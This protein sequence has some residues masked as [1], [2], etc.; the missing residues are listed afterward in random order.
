MDTM[1]HSRRPGFT[2]L[3]IMIVLGI[4][5]GVI[6]LLLPALAARQ[7]R[8]RINEAKIKMR[9]FGDT[10]ELYATDN[11]GYP[12]TE[13]G[14]MALVYIPD[15]VATPATQQPGAMP[16]MGTAAFG[17]GEAMAT[18]PGML[19]GSTP[20]MTD[21]TMMAANPAVNPAMNPGAMNPAATPMG[22][23]DPMN[24]MGTGMA[25]GM[26]GGTMTA[27]TQ[28]THNPAIYTQLRQRPQPYIE[29]DKDLLDP[30]GTP[31]RYDNSLMYAGVNRNGTA[32]P[33]IWSAGPNKL[34]GDEDDI[35]NWDTLDA[36]QK[37]AQ[38]QQMGAGMMGGGM[39]N[40]MMSN[41]MQP[42]SM[43]PNMTQPSAITPNTMQPS[44]MQ[45]NTMPPNGMMPNAVP[46]MTPPTN[47]M[48]SNM[49][50]PNMTPPGGMMPNPMTPA[51]PTMP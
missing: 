4:L 32:R 38:R 2:I 27:W 36:Q 51:A 21:P 1:R 6:A 35:L 46:N 31:Y 18:G 24:P 28:P 44:A 22:M 13:Q 40:L 50:Q 39:S 12:T 17:A 26:A 15:N 7:E 9:Q 45:P 23:A 5:I 30:W 47:T 14:L 33:A 8:V 29:S 41:P 37:I 43:N 16:G 49:M 48:P 42:N 11:R 10:L 3:E 34:D 25:G 20:G 19:G